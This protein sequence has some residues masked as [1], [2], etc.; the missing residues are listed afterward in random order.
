M[1]TVFR[2]TGRRSPSKWGDVNPT[3]ELIGAEMTV[4][5]AGG[6][7][8]SGGSGRSPGG[9]GVKGENPAG[10]ERAG[11]DRPKPMEQQGRPEPD[12]P[13]PAEQQERDLRR[14]EASLLFLKKGLKNENV[15]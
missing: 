4:I 9:M 10:R 1:T 13:K 14:A 12:R 15:Y 5:D 11:E 6:D 7:K 2:P 8:S 3:T